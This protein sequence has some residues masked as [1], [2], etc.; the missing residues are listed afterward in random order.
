MLVRFETRFWKKILSELHLYKD[1]RTF[2]FDSIPLRDADA[3]RIAEAMPGI[4]E[5]VWHARLNHAI[6]EAI[7]QIGA[8]K[9]III[10]YPHV[11]LD[12]VIQHVPHE[13]DELRI[14]FVRYEEEDDERAELDGALERMTIRVLVIGGNRPFAETDGDFLPIGVQELHVQSPWYIG[15]FRPFLADARDRG[16]QKLVCWNV[17]HRDDKPRGEVPIPV[18]RIF[19]TDIAGER[20]VVW[21]SVSGAGLVGFFAPEHEEGDVSGALARE[22]MRG[23]SDLV[24][25]AQVLSQDM[26][27]EEL[28]RIATMTPQGLVDYIGTVQ[29]TRAL[30]FLLLREIPGRKNV[31]ITAISHWQLRKALQSLPVGPRPVDTLCL[32]FCGWL[33]VHF[34]TQSIREILEPFLQRTV[35]RRLEVHRGDTSGDP[36][37]AFDDV[38]R[39]SL[40]RVRVALALLAGRNARTGGPLSALLTDNIRNVAEKVPIAT[41]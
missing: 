37:R 25:P 23:G 18:H 10:I 1:A 9:L 29:V 26:D 8:K 40:A 12:D 3:E 32:I 27:D 17:R 41:S 14:Q 34:D 7:A 21:Q 39:T 33:S 35:V 30:P 31:T 24:F 28:R 15:Q 22:L 5:I 19:G 6:P 36:V 16:L 4:E 11:H 20:D 13:L 38:H 2:E